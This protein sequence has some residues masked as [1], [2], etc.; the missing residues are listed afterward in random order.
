MADL[1]IRT[2][3]IS[4]YIHAQGEVAPGDPD[5]PPGKPDMHGKVSVMVGDTA[6]ATGTPVPSVRASKEVRNG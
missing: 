4:P 2:V 6:T 5:M 3:Q 1:P